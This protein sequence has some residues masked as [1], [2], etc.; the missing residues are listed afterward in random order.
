[1]SRKATTRWHFTF[2]VL[3]VGLSVVSGLV[4]I[5]LYLNFMPKETYGAWLATGNILVWITAVD[6]GLTAV[7]EQRIASAYGEEN[8]RRIQ[9]LLTSGLLITGVI[10]V[11][12]LGTGLALS[13]I[14]ASLIKLG[15]VNPELITSAFEV[16]V[17]GTALTVFSYGLY[18]M[19]KGLQG[20]LASGIILI[21]K[22][23]VEIGVTI[24]L[25]YAG[26]GLMAIPWGKVVGAGIIVAGNAG[27]LIWRT[28]REQKV[29]LRRV[30][31][32]KV[33]ELARLMGY[34]LFGRASNVIA[35]NVDSF[36]VGRY[37]GSDSVAVY[38][39]TKKAPDLVKM[40]INRATV[41]FMPATSHIWGEGNIERAREVLLRVV[42]YLIWGLGLSIGGMLAFNDDFVRLWVGSDLYAGRGVNSLIC[43]L[44][45]A[46]V[47]TKSLSNLCY[48]LGNIKGNS[49]A[50][51]VQSFLYVG[52]SLLGAIKFGIE[53]LIVGA[54]I[55]N[56]LVT[57]WYYIHKFYYLLKLRVVDIKNI[58]LELVLSSFVLTFVLYVFS[59]IH[60]SNWTDFSLGVLSLIISY[61]IGIYILS[62]SFREEVSYFF[63]LIKS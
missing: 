47:L 52:A 58:L 6:P 19:S 30:S 48:A 29:A 28:T 2:Q 44:I 60:I 51:G 38:R 50:G 62:S 57:H 39:L 22:K 8:Y 12:V 18:G 31:G 59:I 55:S 26:Y 27:Y 21:A 34:N 9:N 53:G 61:V 24:R 45:V 36:I 32:R 1:M 16:A 14:V 3:D 63:R 13:T 11:L 54:I 20:T 56:I 7:L 25:L 10:A 41:A 5:P 15:S 17:L 42:S 23:A 46:L 49:I 35:T 43:A 37:I 4:L 40:F 33:I